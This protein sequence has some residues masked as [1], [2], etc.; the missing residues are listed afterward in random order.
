M[1]WGDQIVKLSFK[2]YDSTTGTIRTTENFGYG[3]YF[4]HETRKDILAR[5]WFVGLA[6]KANNNASEVGLNQITFYTEAPGGDG[7]KATPMAS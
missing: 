6:G 1:G 4:K 3:D 2:I 5:G 7:T